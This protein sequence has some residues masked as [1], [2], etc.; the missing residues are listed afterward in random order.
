M[1]RRAWR[2]LLFAAWVSRGA[3]VDAA[4]GVYEF[5]AM[6]RGYAVDPAQ[7]KR[8]RWNKVLRKDSGKQLIEVLEDRDRD[9]KMLY[10]DRALQLSGGAEHMYHEMMA[11]VPLLSTNAPA[12]RVL[13]VGGGDG[14]ISLRVLMH[15]SVREL[16]QVELDEEVVKASKQHFPFIAKAYDDPRLQLHIVDAV[17]WVRQEAERQA[18]SFDACI[19][20]S[21]DEPLISL[22]SKE[23]YAGLRRMIRPGG[24]LMQNIQT[25]DVP[26]QLD[27]LLR[28]Q[29]AGGFERVRAVMMASNDYES[30]YVGFLASGLETA[31]PGPV[32]D[33]E[34]RAV[35]LK[36]SWYSPA[37]HRAS[38]AV[39]PGMVRRWPLFAE[40]AS[41]CRPGFLF[42]PGEA[43]PSPAT[44]PPTPPQASAAA[45]TAPAAQED[46]STDGAP[47]V[48]VVV[49]G[50]GL[51]GVSAAH[52]LTRH[53]G[54]KRVLLLEGR[55][56][57]GGRVETTDPAAFGGVAANVGANWI[58]F[59][60]HNPILRLAERLGC[61][62]A[63]SVN[64]NMRW[65]A[66]GIG[67][68]PESA[69]EEAR[70]F[71]ANLAQRIDGSGWEPGASAA[72]RMQALAGGSFAAPNAT[73]SAARHLHFFGDIVQDHTAMPGDLSGV[74]MCAGVC[75]G[76]PFSQDRHIAGEAGTKCLFEGLLEEV[77]EGS[78]DVRLRSE[79]KTIRALGATPEAGGLLEVGFTR[80]G[81]GGGGLERVRAKGVVVAVPLGVLQASVEDEGRKECASAEC[82]AA[83]GALDLGDTALI[84]FQPRL[85]EEWVAGWGR[86][87]LGQSMRMAFYFDRVFWDIGVEFFS[88]LFDDAVD[89]E[90]VKTA[91]GWFYGEAPAVEF[92]NVVNTTGRPILLAEVGTHLANRLQLRSDE[93]IGE[94]MLDNALR[95]MFPE[96]DV[97]RFQ[98][99]HVKR[100]QADPFLRQALT[101]PSVEG[102]RARASGGGQA[103]SGDV[104]KE[105]TA[106]AKLW[107]PRWGGRLAFA[108]EYTTA[109][110]GTIDGAFLSGLQAA[111]N[112]ACLVSGGS[113][114]TTP[115]DLIRAI[116]IFGDWFP[117]LPKT[118]QCLA[119]FAR[120]YSTAKGD[121]V[122]GTGRAAVG[123]ARATKTTK[124]CDAPLWLED[125]E[126][127]CRFHFEAPPG[128]QT[129]NCLDQGD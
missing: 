29:M 100:Y 38:L 57:L 36:A 74:R 14:G 51:A 95:R 66:Q 67:E 80:H 40:N 87:G 94:Y 114:P 62:T 119:S 99:V 61:P 122:L 47:V 49:V 127:H 82:A 5:D 8:K 33:A 37:M 2:A 121:A 110:M 109:R 117:Q 118:E 21:T 52:M 10:L 15:P 19:I 81:E 59:A 107:T 83:G 16:V 50:G 22:W 55:G 91:D 20:D 85:P 68:L 125:L 124:P 78:I 46:D 9:V 126:T 123:R 120:H 72:R 31:C 79:V 53:L 116:G 7:L 93:E 108:G 42:D 18:D 3:P 111:W 75:G 54:V 113:P 65:I 63:T 13:V 88:Y 128:N 98:A 35:P 11:H 56:E 129:R 105:L 104:E 58:H 12:E 64:G 60:G 77:P 89:A 71:A 1:A 4:P 73:V 44:A 112:I 39:P 101:F 102:E 23:F 6:Y 70:V 28:L 32:A 92:V 48:D 96:V 17:A 106:W 43:A 76:D 115:I 84:D 45:D 69:L 34:E 27:H 97:P 26:K 41:G 103:P 86:Q 90:G 30:P 25:I 24:V